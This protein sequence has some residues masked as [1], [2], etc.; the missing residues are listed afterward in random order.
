MINTTENKNVHFFSK[1]VYLTVS[2]QLHAE[3]L[4]SSMSRVYNIG[5]T[6]R[7][8]KSDSNRHLSEFWMVEAEASFLSQLDDLLNLLEACLKDVIDHLLKQGI[9]DLTIATRHSESNSM[10]ISKLEKW[11]SSP[12]ARMSYTEAINILK[13]SNQKFVYEPRWGAPLQSEHERYLAGTYVDG[14]IFITDYPRKIKP[15]YMRL[16]TTTIPNTPA[17]SAPTVKDNFDTVSCMDLLVPH[18]GEL[19]GGSL[20]EER[21]SILLK[22]FEQA[23][24]NKEDY[25][26]YLD[27]RRFGTAPHGGFGIGLER[28][29]QFMTGIRN[30]RD[31][32]PMP[33]WYRHCEL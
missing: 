9:D 12:F 16:N 11:I 28:F 10:L 32:V 19:A 27:L 29:L 31:L 2:G 3:A 18:V 14:P 1:P 23:G 17:H 25:D 22:N 30:V 8:E 5:P 21:Y 20:R 33:R 4:A 15:F 7:A 6:F 26:W 13:K 24:M